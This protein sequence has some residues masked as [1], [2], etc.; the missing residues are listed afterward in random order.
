MNRLFLALFFFLAGI[1]NLTQ[2]ADF[3]VISAGVQPKMVKVYGAGGLRGLEGYQSGFL[4]S[5]QGHI[6]TVWSYVLDTDYITVTLDDGRKF[7]GKIV[8]ADPRLEV[9]V[10]K[11][12]TD[13][14]EYFKLG[15]SVGVKPGARILAFSNLFKIAT[16][17]EPN[18]VL[19]GIVAATTPLNARRG[20][21]KTTYK[22]TVYILDAIT[23]NPG[24]AGG[25]LTT[26]NGELAGL[27][28]KEL[29]N[30]QNGTWLNYAMPISELIP[31]IEDIIAGRTRP[32]SF[33]DDVIR[34]DEP[35]T[36]K[37][38]GIRM[39]PD[40]LAKTP[41]F[42][43]SV[44]AS[45]EAEKKGIRP[46][47]LL[48]YINDRRVD[49]CATLRSELELIDQIDDVILVVQRGDEL[50]EIVLQGEQ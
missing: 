45:S 27:L 7:E 15:A 6:L 19:H 44:A 46:D 32:R 48:L 34:P 24:A 40:V 13:G 29:R 5:D 50:V 3:S 16:G 39:V 36:L 38:L 37:T 31:A 26:R 18:S 25:A 43:D 17:D 22:G 30:S 11:I 35:H 1:I 21:F 23:N 12:D 8:G 42:V 2:A 33:D 41:P 9:A 28:G 47:D 49:S 10:L 4:I 20:A 14:L